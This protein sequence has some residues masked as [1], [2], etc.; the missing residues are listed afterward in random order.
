MLQKTFEV[1]ILFRSRCC[2]ASES[3]NNE[4]LSNLRRVKV[5]FFSHIPSGVLENFM[6]GQTIG[7]PLY[8]FWSYGRGKV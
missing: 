5:D 6:N 3:A 7:R 8:I 1:F 4:K 2:V